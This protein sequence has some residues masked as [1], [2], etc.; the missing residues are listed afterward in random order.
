[1][2]SLEMRLA[3]VPGLDL[4]QA[5][6][7]LGGKV[8]GLE[9]VL[10]SFAR[11]YADGEAGLL[12]SEGKD[13]RSTWRHVCHS[14]RGACESIGAASLAQ[15]LTTFEQDLEDGADIAAQSIRARA[16]NATLVDFV[17]VLSAALDGPGTRSR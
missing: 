4:N 3:A 15:A 2:Q 11:N 10:R 13:I 6:R 9:K 7:L 1:V 17:A 16:L 12:V 5:L 14:L 8:S